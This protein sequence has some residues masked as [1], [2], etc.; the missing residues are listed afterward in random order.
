MKMPKKNE[1]RVH[2]FDIAGKS[3]TLR[4]TWT[5][6][7]VREPDYAI[8]TVTLDGK[9]FDAG[10]I[11]PLRVDQAAAREARRE[12]FHNGCG[13]YTP[14]VEAGDVTDL[15]FGM[16]GNL[17]DLVEAVGLNRDDPTHY[18]EVELSV[19]AASLA[20]ARKIGEPK[21]T[22]YSSSRRRPPASRRRSATPRP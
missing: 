8:G 7:D 22:A 12:D 15:G 3:A 9:E 21:S 19:R 17:Q 6:G 5:T 1:R 14:T 18:D 11:N 20:L 10:G 16:I 2:T 4:F 13:I